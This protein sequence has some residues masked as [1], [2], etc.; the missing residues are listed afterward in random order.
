MYV[1]QIYQANHFVKYYEI[2][3]SLQFYLKPF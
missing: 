2:F 3:E 1:V